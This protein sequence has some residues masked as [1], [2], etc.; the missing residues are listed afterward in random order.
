MKV[1]DCTICQERPQ[2]SDSALGLCVRCA[3]MIFEVLVQE[4]MNSERK[5]RLDTQEE[6]D[7][8]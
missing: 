7:R 3:A 5:D 4:A 8:G 1:D 2:L 6:V